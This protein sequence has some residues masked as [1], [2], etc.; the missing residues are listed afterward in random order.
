MNLNGIYRRGVGVG[1]WGWGGGHTHTHTH[2]HTRTTSLKKK[3][4]KRLNVV[5]VD[6]ADR[7]TGCVSLNPMK[8]RMCTVVWGLLPAKTCSG[9]PTERTV[10]VGHRGKTPEVL[11]SPML[12]EQHYRL[13][14]RQ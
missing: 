5:Q 12:I 4:N 3:I 9:Y 7:R 8:L 10:T 2:T 1:G 14:L 11:P 13:K 6:C